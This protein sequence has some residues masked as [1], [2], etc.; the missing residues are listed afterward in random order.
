M[1]KSNLEEM[2][3]DEIARRLLDAKDS[4]HDDDDDDS[5]DDNEK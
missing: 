4:E 3:E 5:K 1:T 2:E